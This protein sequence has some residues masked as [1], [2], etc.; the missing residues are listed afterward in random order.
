MHIYLKNAVPTTGLMVSL[1]KKKKMKVAIFFLSQSPFSQNEKLNGTHQSLN[2]LGRACGIIVY[3]WLPPC[4]CHQ[5]ASECLMAGL[6]E[7][8]SQ[9]IM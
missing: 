8:E 6:S 5:S 4:L 3:P 7:C 9:I 1:K 2:T